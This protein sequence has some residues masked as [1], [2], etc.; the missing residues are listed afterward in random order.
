MQGISI[1]LAFLSLTGSTLARP[2][3]AEPVPSPTT[4]AIASLED[5][6]LIGDLTGAV[7]GVLGDAVGDINNALSTLR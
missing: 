2:A 3:P 4:T 1:A 7:S 6:D 5:R